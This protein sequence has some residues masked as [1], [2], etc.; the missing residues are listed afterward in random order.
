MGLEGL[1]DKYKRTIVQKW[2][3]SVVRTYPADTA[4]FLKRQKD[5][6]ANP[7]GR[8]TYKGLEGMYDQLLGEMDPQAI[9]PFL[10]P[11]IRIRAV[12]DFTPSR[13]AGFVFNLKGIIR[14]TIGD[15]VREKE[16]LEALMAIE[17]RIDR[18]GLLAFDIFMGCREKVYQL[19]ANEIRN[20]VFSAFHRA[21]L[22]E[23]TSEDGPDTNKTIE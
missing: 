8:T 5:P 15:Q 3:D 19:K 10:D 12:Q 23:D 11:I 2:F 18:I 21:G 13:A 16:G 9:V 20:R 17:E 7:V 1:F 14:E 22:V 6:F 4:R